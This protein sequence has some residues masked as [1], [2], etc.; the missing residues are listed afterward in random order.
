MKRLQLL[1][2]L[3]GLFFLPTVTSASVLDEPNPTNT[4]LVAGPTITQCPSNLTLNVGSS[5][6]AVVPNMLATFQATD[7]CATPTTLTYAQSPIAGTILS[8]HGTVLT[9]VFTV[10]DN[11]GQSAMCSATVTVKDRDAP[12]LCVLPP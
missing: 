3:L 4:R 2:P 6:D 12:I 8:G 9:V 5:C 10:T 7:N 1:L 11:C